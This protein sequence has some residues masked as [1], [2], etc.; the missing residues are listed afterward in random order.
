M[1]IP[2]S[3]E[4]ALTVSLSHA[5]GILSATQPLTVTLTEGASLRDGDWSHIGDAV[6][7]TWQ[8]WRREDGGMYPVTTS[9]HLAITAV[10]N[11]AGGTLTLTTDG[12]Q[13]AGTYLLLVTQY[14]HGYP[15]LKTPVWVFIDY[16]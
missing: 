4:S 8:M 16:R 13:P 10:Q 7:L 15:V 14:Y 5:A 11:D 3:T 12:K 6:D 9:E 2:V 1:T